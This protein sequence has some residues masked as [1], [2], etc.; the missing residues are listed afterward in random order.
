MASLLGVPPE[1]RLV[2]EQAALVHHAPLEAFETRALDRLVLDVRLPSWRV[3]G[4]GSIFGLL[5]QAK[6]LVRSMHHV[7]GQA[8]A[9]ETPLLA[10]ILEVANLFD[11]RLELLPY[12]EVTAERIRSEMAVLARHGYWPEEVTSALDRLQ[13]IDD[14]EIRRVAQNLPVFPTVVFKAVALSADSNATFAQLEKLLGSDQVL[15]G[16]LIRAANSGLHGRREEVKTIRHAA[17]FLGLEL[18][19]KVLAAAA[20]RPLVASTDLKTLWRHSL[21]TAERMETLAA[22]SGAAPPMEAYLAGLVHDIGRLVILR[23]SGG[24]ARAYSRLLERGCAP[25]FAEHVLAGRDHGE[26][27]ATVLAIWKFP[28][29]IREAV[30]RHHRPE[31]SESALASLLYL[32]ELPEGEDGPSG[33]RIDYATA[34]AGLPAATV[35]SAPVDRATA[36]EQLVAVA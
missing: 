11:E 24:A 17:A 35:S 29:H 28:A 30:R 1:L 13:T 16:E 7:G 8:P 14:G 10:G 6:E 22:R 4:S 2:L 32:S 12:E 36:V 19:R 25:V 31:Q 26:I 33:I 34:R 18:T 23:S 9:R 15:A 21:E 27:G 3:V 5:G 20:L